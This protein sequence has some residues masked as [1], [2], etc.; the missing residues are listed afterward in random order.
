MD[1]MELKQIYLSG[2]CEKSYGVKVDFM[3]LC[4]DKPKIAQ[5]WLNSLQID[6]VDKIYNLKDFSKGPQYILPKIIYPRF[7]N[8][9]CIVGT[10]FF[11][12]YKFGWICFK[13]TVLRCHSIHSHEKFE[14]YQCQKC[15]GTTEMPVLSE[16]FN[17]SE[18]PR[19]CQNVLDDL[20][21]GITFKKIQSLTSLYVDYQE[22]KIQEHS[23]IITDHVPKSITI[24]LQND[25]VDNCQPGDAVL[26]T[27]V[28]KRR[29]KTV[30]NK[31][32]IEWY[33]LA[34]NLIVENVKVIEQTDLD[35]RAIWNNTPS[36]FNKRKKAVESFCPNILGQSQIKLSLILILIGGVSKHTETKKQRGEPHLLL[37][38]HP[39]TGKSQ[40]LQ[41]ITRLMPRSVLT[42]GLG[43]TKA[44]L[45]VTALKEGNEWVLEAGALVLADKG[46][47]CIDEFTTMRKADQTAIH[48]A[49]EQQ[50]LSI[51]KAGMQST[52]HTR[53]SVIAACNPNYKRDFSNLSENLNIAT[54]LLSR[55]DLIIIL[56]NDSNASIDKSIADFILKR[57]S[58]TKSTSQFL[59]DSTFS[60]FISFCKLTFNPKCT[61][62][63]AIVFKK[64]YQYK[65]NDVQFVSQGRATVR[66]VE[67][68]LRLSEAHA[69]LCY[70]DV[71]NHIDVFTAILL[72]ELAD[73][74]HSCLKLTENFLERDQFVQYQKEICDII[75][76]DMRSF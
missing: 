4:H 29:Y 53:C 2:N 14:L 23:H 10:S 18:A 26:V 27:G 63:L 32:T 38:G 22:I 24:V 37:V 42:T 36:D 58:Q 46:V 60:Q 69:R 64:Y 71:I 17:K 65:R 34:N 66:M 62:E 57:E 44:G 50:T 51:A 39:G 31:P 15:K 19:R 8:F 61:P 5:K 43:S 74:L 33:I 48:E 49:M 73:P 47:C 3:Q 25:L 13:G 21:G 11:L 35:M 1:L 75:G 6:T 16:L 41:A 30:F 28:M 59:D 72:M 40:Y 52:L 7:Y 54:S 68:L 9:E 20:C 76:L 70:R 45:T 12:Q 55:F 56:S 67:S